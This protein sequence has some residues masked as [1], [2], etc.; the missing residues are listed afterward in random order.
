MLTMSQVNCIRDLYKN[1]Y[2]ICEIEEKTG[3]CHKTI[4]KYLGTEML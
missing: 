1:G 4:K 3:M 2:R